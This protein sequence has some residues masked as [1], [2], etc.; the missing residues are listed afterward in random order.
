MEEP[1][2]WLNLHNVLPKADVPAASAVISHSKWQKP[3]LSFVKCNVG[4]SW[5]ENSK[6]GG[7]A[8]IFRDEKGT[9]L[10]HSRRAFLILSCHSKPIW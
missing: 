8:W 9:I 7:G 6:T 2:I 3:P 10:F 5:D 1:A 4:A